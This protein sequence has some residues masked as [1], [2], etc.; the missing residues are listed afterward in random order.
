MNCNTNNTDPRQTHQGAVCACA[1]I[2]REKLT[3]YERCRLLR[4]L[5]G[6]L[7]ASWL[8][9]GINLITTIT[10]DLTW[11][12]PQASAAPVVSVNDTAGRWAA[13]IA[14]SLTP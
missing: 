13:V 3:A 6:V 7:L 9:L 10:T 11:Q 8:F 5:L 1:R 14:I 4:G 2:S 12:F